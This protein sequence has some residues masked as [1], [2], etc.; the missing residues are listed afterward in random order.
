M[1]T[2]TDSQGQSYN[3]PDNLSDEQKKTLF[4]NLSGGTN[5]Q[6]SEVG[7]RL[8][9]EG[10]IKAAESKLGM[11]LKR[12]ESGALDEFNVPSVRFDTSKS[13]NLSSVVDK[14]SNKFPEATITILDEPVGDERVVITIP[15]S[16]PV[17]LDSDEAFSVSDMADVAGSLLTAETL[18]SIMG[19]IRT[20][21]LSLVKRAVGLGAGGA[22]GRSVDLGVEAARGYD[23]G[24][25][26]DIFADVG[27]SF[28]LGV[29]AEPVASGI[30]RGA[31]F[32][33]GKGAIKLNQD[34]AAAIRSFKDANVRGPSVGQIHPAAQKMEAQAAQ[35][36]KSVQDYRINQMRDALEALKR[37][38]AEVG[39]ISNL[40]DAHVHRLFNSVK[41][42]MRVL[43]EHGNVSPEIAGKALVK[44]RKAFKAASREL[45]DRKYSAAL[46]AGADAK[47]SISSLK[48]LAGDID[49]GVAARGEPKVVGRRI[50]ANLAQVEVTKASDVQLQKT[51]SDL[52]SAIDD[53]LSM[54]K[55]VMA[56]DGKSGF[57]Q[58]KTLRTRLFDI[59]NATIDGKETIQNRFAGQLWDELTRII[60][61]PSGGS[62]KFKM[63]IRAANMSNRRI[64]RIMS[65]D[66]VIKISRET[67]P[68]L[69]GQNMVQPGKAFSLR[70]L[71]RIM[72][73]EQWGK[74]TDGYYTGLLNDPSTIE[75]S[76]NKFNKDK[77]ALRVVLSENEEN[78]LRSYGREWKSL[79]SLQDTIHAQS[80]SY[81]RV[82]HLVN[83]GNTKQLEL[84]L[85]KGGGKESAIGRSLRVGVFKQIMDKGAKV[86]K[87]RHVINANSALAEIKR[88]KNSGVLETIMTPRD[89]AI[90]ENREIMLSILPT[91]ADA[92]AAIRGAELVSDATG[93][94]E[95]P[96]V[97]KKAVTGFIRGVTGIARN[98]FVGNILI[99]EK[100]ARYLLGA[101]EAAVE[102][103]L[104]T[105][106][107][108]LTAIMAETSKN[109]SGNNRKEG[110]QR[111]RERTRER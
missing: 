75:S 20:R 77:S 76:L 65:L 64:E 31:R 42:E 61:N 9:R 39:S 89:I 99:S 4:S 103:N 15:G 27:L 23:V 25:M 91:S 32:V 37:D 7:K 105:S 47:F 109:L 55:E 26:D 63:L 17:L 33:S 52:K 38:A 98:A 108:A 28:G 69:L 50:N 70:T 45:L 21:G 16:Q 81:Q 6:L 58:L 29:A 53:I 13:T 5:Q 73:K 106:L 1:P 71:K 8:D 19:A 56:Y 10:A 97:P 85:N 78:T 54:E 96:I 100:G 88:L 111:S 66:D 36:S 40:D 34:D 12:D 80:Q 87:G 68:G 90:L 83:S 79:T 57:E 74:F 18:G 84:L 93:I 101:G 41:D 43:I 24:E 102:G 104:Q 3:I 59:K 67:N 11:P 95:A 35:T 60:D 110:A 51:S 44:G 82:S 94:L 62:D 2:F 46:E 72:P 30:G 86:E 14:L 92:G 49:R 48:K 22:A 107:R